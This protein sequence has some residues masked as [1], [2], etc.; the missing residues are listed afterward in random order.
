MSLLVLPFKSL[1]WVIDNHLLSLTLHTSRCRK[2]IVFL[3]ERHVPKVTCKTQVFWRK[4]V[5]LPA[6]VWMVASVFLA[7]SR[8]LLMSSGNAL[9]TAM[10]TAQALQAMALFPTRSACKLTRSCQISASF[11]PRPCGFTTSFLTLALILSSSKRMQSS[12]LV[13]AWDVMWAALK[14]F[15]PMARVH[16]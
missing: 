1:L 13:C 8:L 7:C 10:M 15:R 4:L 14:I 11:Y 3:S 6:L 12:N 9:S 5:L 2:L 16:L